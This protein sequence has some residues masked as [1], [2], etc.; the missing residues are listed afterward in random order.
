LP[1]FKTSHPV[2]D[3]TIW[4]RIGGLFFAMAQ[5]KNGDKLFWEEKFYAM[6]GKTKACSVGAFFPLKFGGGKDIFSFFSGSQCVPTMFLLSST[7]GSHQFLN[8]FPNMF[9]IAL[10]YYPICFGKCCSPF[11][12]I[13]GPKGKNSILQN[14]TFYFGEPP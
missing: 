11:T 8:I 10:R 5:S 13:G 7:M 12:Y 1:V 3:Q 4:S 2:L 9:S 14:I 6:N